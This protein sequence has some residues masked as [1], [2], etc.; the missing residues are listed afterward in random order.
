V[1]VVRMGVATALACTVATTDSLG[2]GISPSVTH[3]IRGLTIL[4][5]SGLGRQVG[6]HL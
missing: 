3:V 6:P 4:P 1:T 5:E 2:V